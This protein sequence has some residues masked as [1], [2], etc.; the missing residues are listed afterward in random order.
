MKQRT[1]KAIGTFA[2]VSFMIVYALVAMAVGGHFAVGRGMAVEL[3][4][5]VLAGLLWIPVVMV[6]I[7]WMVKP[8]PA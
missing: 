3:I 5:F 4:Y 8:D 1:R 7:R 6:I 2:T